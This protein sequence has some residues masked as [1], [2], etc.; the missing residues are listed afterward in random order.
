M[1]GRD[2]ELRFLKQYY[3]REGSQILVVYG[4]RGVGKTA[5]L[6]CF[7]EGKKYAFYC[8]RAC[9]ER[10][11]RY[12][13]A[14]ELKEAGKELS[15][16]PEYTE[17]FNNVFTEEETE[18]Q[19]LVIEEFHHIIKSDAAFLPELIR[20]L[21]NRRLARPVMVVLCTSASGWVENS[22]IPKIGSQAAAISGL[23]KVRELRYEDIRKLFPGYSEEDSVRIYAAL[24]GIPGLWNSFSEK[25]SAKENLIQNILRKDSRLH[26]EMSYYMAEELREPA[27]YN[28]ILAVMATGC[29]KLNDIYRHTGFSR[30]KISVYLK[31]LME[32]ELVEKVFS[33][34]YRIANP[35]VRFYFSFLFPHKSNLSR[36]TPEEYYHKYVEQAY[37]DYVEE[38]YRK[39]CK[40]KLQQEYT[41]VEEW[42]WKPGM[43]YLRAEK[44]DGSLLIAACSY[45]GN[46]TEED[47]EWMQFS[48]KKSKLK[49]EETYLFTPDKKDGN[50]WKKVCL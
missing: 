25:L 33:G 48:M 32:L 29:N 30:A 18:K 8:A 22:M 10:E 3:E 6:H 42:C 16:Y 26:E 7:S 28:T 15:R 31:N 13:W 19:V 35:Y 21:E 17:I 27:V 1:T 43:V 24:G 9:S 44:A 50:L 38:A 45:A 2:G 34:T 40:D 39:I 5:L 47:R 37:P 11:Q 49:A 12:Q 23:L 41:R 4:Q 14:V 20:F 46:F 36:L